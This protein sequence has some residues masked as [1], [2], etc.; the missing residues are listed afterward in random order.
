MGML[1]RIAGRWAEANRRYMSSHRKSSDVAGGLGALSKSLR[2]MIQ[3]GVLAVGA[4]LVI[5]QQAS[6][7]IIS[8]GSILSARALAPV[9]LAIAHWGFVAA[10]QSWH[11]LQAPAGC[12]LRITDRCRPIEAAVGRAVGIVPPGEQRVIVRD[13]TFAVDAGTGVGVINQRFGKSS[14]VRAL[15]GV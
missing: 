14:L 6:A 10:R 3:S 7:G 11:R 8:A 4:C 12:R 1:S 2:M 5:H 15:V 13:V 9:D